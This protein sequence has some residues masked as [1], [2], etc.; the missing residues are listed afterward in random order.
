MSCFCA[1]LNCPAGNDGRGP[2]PAPWWHRRDF[3]L[4]HKKTGG[5]EGVPPA[6]FWGWPQ[7]RPRREFIDAYARLTT[8]TERRSSG[9]GTRSD[10]QRLTHRGECRVSRNA[11]PDLRHRSTFFLAPQAASRFDHLHHACSYVE[12]INRP[13]RGM[14]ETPSCN[15]FQPRSFT[16]KSPPPFAPVLY[17]D[18]SAHAGVQATLGLPGK[19]L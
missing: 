6:G 10:M 12:V 3:R 5:P 9:R 2:R 19:T 8:D 16:D 7:S 15:S 14:V 11:L 4:W 17:P 1:V 13:R 18:P